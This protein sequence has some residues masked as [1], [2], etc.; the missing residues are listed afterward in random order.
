MSGRKGEAD[1][2]Q[3][4]GQA[5][6]TERGGGMSAGVDFPF[7]RDG[8]HLSARD[9]DKISEGVKDKATKP[10]SRV[11]IAGWG[12]GGFIGRRWRVR[13]LVGH[14]RAQAAAGAQEIVEAPL[15]PATVVVASLS[16]V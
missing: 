10:K 9:G 13:F 4:G 8:E 2:R 16:E 1:D 11:G 7:Q 6:E 15:F 3:G 5:D 12:R 14:R